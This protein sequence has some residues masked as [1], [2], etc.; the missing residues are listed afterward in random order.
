VD[1]HHQNLAN[2]E[3]IQS[4]I[5]IICL[6]NAC[7]NNDEEFSRIVLHGPSSNRWFDKTQLIVCGNG[8]AGMV[9]FFFFFLKKKK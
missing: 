6:D 3:K 5:L 9:T 2:L 1:H 4:A 7:P 8:R